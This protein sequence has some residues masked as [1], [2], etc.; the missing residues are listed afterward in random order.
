MKRIRIVR[1]GCGRHGCESF[2]FDFGPIRRLRKYRGNFRPEEI[3][4][5]ET[6]FA[7]LDVDEM[8]AELETFKAAG[9]KAEVL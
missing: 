2:Y 5:H 1:C 6:I 3:P 8:I 7:A 9:Y 4:D